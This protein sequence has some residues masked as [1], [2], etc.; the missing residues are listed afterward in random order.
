M[1]SSK[2]KE[3]DCFIIMPISDPEGYEDGHF[4]HVYENIIQPACEQANVKPIRADDVKETN[5]IHLDVLKKLIDS[6][7]A[8]CDLSTRNPNVLF[9][10]GIRQAFDKPVVLIQ[11]VGT[12]R[13]FDIAPLRYLEYSR[14]M[15]YHDVLK[16]Q[17]ELKDAISATINAEGDSGNINS[18]VKLLALSNPATI[19]ELEGNKK[20]VFAIEVLQSEM[21]EIRKMMEMLLLEGR[22]KPKNSLIAVEYER[23]SNKLD[24]LTNTRR[25]PLS[26]KHEEL[27][28]LLEESKEL[29]MVAED[30]VEMMHIDRLMRKIKRTL[31]NIA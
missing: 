27:Q 10:L 31:S 20:E 8:I 22:I 17:S 3:I 25:I 11:E 29:M 28:A 30:K 23:I 7:I 2:A 12:P 19:P 14:D 4:R 26:K 16:S 1:T 24:Q 13:I 21:M 9:E 18:I 6:P 15:K 5:L